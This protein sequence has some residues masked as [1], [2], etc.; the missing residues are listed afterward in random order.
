[1]KEIN[2]AYAVLSDREKRQNYDRYGD[3][4][5]FNQGSNSNGGF[6]RQD[7]FFR[8]IFDTIF[9]KNSD[10][11]GQRNYS[12]SRTNSQDGSDILVDLVLNFKESVLGVKK[13]ISLELE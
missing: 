2:Q 12:E 8:D 13:K 11:G 3:E 6:G 7:S 5:F 4:K 10:H 9:G 1:M